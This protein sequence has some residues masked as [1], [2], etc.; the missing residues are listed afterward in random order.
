MFQ[1]TL[2]AYATSPFP[3]ASICIG[4]IAYGLVE[5]LSLPAPLAVIAGGVLG[6]IAWAT[7]MG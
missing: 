2:N 6:V 5:V 3:N 7:K 4:I 1:L